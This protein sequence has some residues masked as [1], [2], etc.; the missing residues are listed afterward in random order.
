MEAKH[1]KTVPTELELNH[2][3]IDQRN[4][5]KFTC[6]VCNKSLTK[7]TAYNHF[8]HV[9]H[10][11]L[12]DVDNDT[13]SK[14][15]VCKDGTRMSNR[16][17]QQQTQS[18][19]GDAQP[20]DLHDAPDEP[21]ADD[22]P[23]ASSSATMSELRLLSSQLLRIEQRDLQRSKRMTPDCKDLRIADD[24]QQWQ[25]GDAVSGFAPMSKPLESLLIAGSTFDAHMRSLSGSELK[26]STLKKH[27]LGF[28]YFYCMWECH[29]HAANK[30]EYSDKAIQVGLVVQMQKSG[31]IAELLLLPALDK[32]NGWVAYFEMHVYYYH[33]FIKVFSK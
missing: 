10:E 11:L 7:R 16:R 20:E 33:N 1:A 28:R 22:N 17:K 2:V 14:W 24:V 21:E 31:A 6:K 4:N 23:A 32:N 3:A 30:K 13:L 8:R 18:P 9:K 12:T 15:V 25:L 29:S 5:L 19:S 26:K 27:K